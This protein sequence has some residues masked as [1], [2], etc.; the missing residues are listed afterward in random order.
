MSTQIT[1]DRSAKGGK[2]P[3]G[4]TLERFAAAKSSGYNKREKKEKQFALDAKKV[5][6]YR[7][8]KQKLQQQGMLPGVSQAEQQETIQQRRLLERAGSPAADGS[9]DDADADQ[10]AQPR[11]D[12]NAAS[13]QNQMFKKQSD[14]IVDGV[15]AARQ[16]HADV[17]ASV[18]RSQGPVQQSHDANQSHKQHRRQKPES[19]LQ[20]LAKQIQA[21]KDA[22]M[23]NQQQAQR[24][25]AERRA[26]VAEVEKQ[27]KRQ[28]SLLRKKTRSGQPIMKHRIDKLLDALQQ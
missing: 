10:S 20:K 3:K 21:D 1:K 16:N 12:D 5:N 25:A 17:H 13:Q 22:A 27:R 4:L 2:H 24:E 28:T 7:K 8:L 6:K 15:I 19:H 9:D 26:R 11:H 18:D 23:Q 14:C